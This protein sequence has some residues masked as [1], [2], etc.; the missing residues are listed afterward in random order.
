M[1]QLAFYISILFVVVGCNSRSDF[2][3]PLNYNNYEKEFQ[4]GRALN[5]KDLKIIFSRLRDEIK[6]KTIGKI[7]PVII[8]ED[9]LGQKIPLRKIITSKTLLLFSSA[10][11]GW[12]TENLSRDMPEVLKK[13]ETNNIKF[14]TVC[15]LTVSTNDNNDPGNFNLF[16]KV[17]SKIY[18]HTFKINDLEARKMNVF[19]SPTRI[20][21]GRDFEVLNYFDGAGLKDSIYK[22]LS[23]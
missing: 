23:R 21:I 5:E 17:I 12:G 19:G 7:M 16:F 11:C 8:I 22:E 2:I 10:N 14:N 20:M 3:I 1:K 4:Q 6:R 13:L 18:P 9:S 15:L